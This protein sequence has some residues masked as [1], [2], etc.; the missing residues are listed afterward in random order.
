MAS[1]TTTR[2]TLERNGKT[3]DIPIQQV[4][5]ENLR[6]V[7]QVRKLV[8]CVL[9]K[10]VSGV[11]DLACTCQSVMQYLLILIHYYYLQVDPAEVWLRDDCDGTAYFPQ[12]GHFHLHSMPTYSMLVVEGP[13]MGGGQ[14]TSNSRQVSVTSIP[15]PTSSLP[16]PTFR[17]VTATRRGPTFSLKVVK[18]TMQR[19]GRG[20]A[21]FQPTSQTYLELTE[22][23]ANVEHI[24]GV[25][26]SRW[27]AEYTLV[28]NDGL[29]IEDST[30]TQGMHVNYCSSPFCMVFIR[31]LCTVLVKPTHIWSSELHVHVL[32]TTVN[33]HFCLFLSQCRSDV[34]EEPSPKAVRCDENGHQ[35]GSI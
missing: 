4:T 14:R 1:Q 13:E 35:G 25:I 18:A 27:G 10:Y 7:F 33:N 30:A 20:K 28:T 31:V 5:V 24:L 15:T 17:S 29:E 34:L 19:Q 3:A 9:I 22:A 12:E 21:E 8:C 26:S 16:P 6:R 11:W 23:T 2:V 32:F